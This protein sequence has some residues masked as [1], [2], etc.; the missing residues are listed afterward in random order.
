MSRRTKRDEELI[1]EMRDGVYHLCTDGLQG[2]LIFNNH[3]QYAFGMFLMGLICYN[4]NITIYAFVLMPNHL[5]V[6]LKGDGERCLLAFYFIRRKL[7]ARL[8]K[9]GFA[10]LSKEYWFK[11]V[12]IE[13][14][15]Q[16]KQEIVYVLRNPLEKGISP[17]CSYLW[18]TGSMY[19]YPKLKEILNCVPVSSI[20][21]R[22][23]SA[24]LGGEDTLPDHWLVNDYLGLLPESFVDV[25]SVR[26]LFPTPKDLQA[27]LVKDYESFFQIANKLGEITEFSKAETEAIVNQV[28][29]N[30]FGGRELK[31][32]TAMEKGKLIIILNSEFGFNSYKI[33][34]SVFVKESIVRQLLSSKEVLK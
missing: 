26:S 11:L 4:Y 22:K 3:E 24:L 27:A 30:R 33:S 16:L 14:E 15:K 12:P 9:D 13:S 17:A 7:S 20:S 28:L 2:Q 8:S 5:H 31:Q 6:I 23:M 1:K 10:P 32:L 18:G 34:T 29:Q 25:S 19:Y 21:K